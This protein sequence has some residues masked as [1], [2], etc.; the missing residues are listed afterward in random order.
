MF[1]KDHIHHQLNLIESL[2]IKD[3][4]VFLLRLNQI[5]CRE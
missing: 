2:L 1:L 5:E 3:L 4:V